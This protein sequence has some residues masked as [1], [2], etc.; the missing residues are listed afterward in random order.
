MKNR[1][2]NLI[3]DGVDWTVTDRRYKRR[4][5]LSVVAFLAVWFALIALFS[6]FGTWDQSNTSF[7]FGAA[8]GALFAG[9]PIGYKY[10]RAFGR[11]FQA[12]TDSQEYIETPVEGHY[13][14]V[15]RAPVK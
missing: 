15:Y 1:Q 5:A 12:A 7:L 8:A 3:I 9:L 11:V 13:P 14:K 2:N 4:V 10:G 6:L